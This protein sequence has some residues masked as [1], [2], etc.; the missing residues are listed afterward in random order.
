M[1]IFYRDNTLCSWQPDNSAPYFTPFS[2]NEDLPRRQ[3][4][5][6][7]EK[8]SS[9]KTEI[10]RLALLY[11]LSHDY[12][13]IVSQQEPMIGQQTHLRAPWTDWLTPLAVMWI[14]TPFSMRNGLIVGK[15]LALKNKLLLYFKYKS[16]FCVCV[17]VA[18]FIQ[19]PLKAPVQKIQHSCLLES[20][21]F[22]LKYHQSRARSSFYVIMKAKRG[23][24]YN[25]PLT[26]CLL[27]TALHE[28]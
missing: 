21:W 27:S 14:G 15:L 10:Q 6:T 13:M 28:Q 9:L 19:A 20:I 18:F 22:T 8:P 4:V 11:I 26:L 5:K 12:K 24:L 1:N 25:I 17:A 16:Y 7:E 3:Q 23:W 2:L